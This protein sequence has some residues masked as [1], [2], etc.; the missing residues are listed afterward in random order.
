MLTAVSKTTDI[1]VRGTL[2]S[3]YRSTYDILV[4]PRGFQTPLERTQGLISNNDLG[5]IFGG[6]TLSQ[7]RRVLRT[8]GVEV[9]APVANIGF[10]IPYAVPQVRLDDLLSRASVQLYRIR[11]ESVAD[12]GTSRYPHATSYAYVTQHGR[13]AKGPTGFTEIAPNGTRTALPLCNTVAMESAGPFARPSAVDC[14]S[15]NSSNVSTGVQVWFPILLA[16]IDPVEESRLVDLGGAVVSGRYLRESEGLRLQLLAGGPGRTYHRLVPIIA[17]TRTYVDQDVIA[18]VERLAIPNPASLANVL[19]SAHARAFLGE[20]KGTEVARRVIP[21]QASYAEALKGVFGANGAE[22]ISW[23]YWTSSGVRYTMQHGALSPEPMVNPPSVW[24]DSASA[25]S[26]SYQQAPTA[27]ADAQFRRLYPRIGSAEWGASGALTGGQVLD[28]PVMDIVGRYD[29]AKLPGFSR[30]T[31][32]PLETYYPPELLPADRASDLA[33]GGKLLLPSENFG[34]YVSQPPLFLT[35]LQAM[36]AFLNPQYYAGAQAEAPISVIRV[37]VAGVNGPDALSQARVRAVA[38]EIHDGTGLQVDITAGSS[39]QR[40]LIAL[41]AGRFGRPPLL[42]AEEWSK[43][44]VSVSFLRALDRKRLGLLLLILFACGIFVAGAGYASVRGRRKEIGILTCL[45]WSRRAVFVAIMSELVLVGAFAGAVGFAAAAVIQPLLSL[46]ASLARAALVVP[47]A[48]VLSLVA[49]VLPAWG[50]ARTA[51]IDTIVTQASAPTRRR[52]RRGIVSMGLANVRRMPGRNLAG[53]TGLLVAAGAMTLLLAIDDAFRGR[54]VGTLLGNAVAV[55]VRG[56]DFLAVGLVALLGTLSL[57]DAAHLNL[58]ERSAETSTLRAVGWSEVQLVR[59]FFV[60]TV[61]VATI[62]T[63]LGVL[64]GGALGTALGVP[65]LTLTQAG[66][67]S[68]LGGIMVALLVSAAASGF[69]AR[70]R[71]TSLRED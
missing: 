16:A 29:P 53:G 59:L 19:G 67:V 55:Q 54:L 22:N 56:L 48:I 62:A 6:I 36:Q 52:P 21:A 11:Y 69:G 42:L 70:K 65:V 60:E 28:T 32:V 15:A 12:G 31:R 18:H 38:M 57:F 5:G 10:V 2:Q 40:M 23:S 37:R 61:T 13:I 35:T 33:L 41:P 39:P 9:A 68:L 47:L 66:G 20:L 46:H 30:L 4:R 3:N 45:G 26:G 63:G 25:G 43:K 49:G 14:Y 58:K 64:F 8:E 44:G 51:P 24:R 17:S 71:V 27:N 34:G 7:Y 50:A 1:R